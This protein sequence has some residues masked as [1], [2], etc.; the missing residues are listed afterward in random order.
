MKGLKNWRKAKQL[1]L[2]I[3]SAHFLT[4]SSFNPISKIPAEQCPSRAIISVASPAGLPVGYCPSTRRRSSAGSQYHLEWKLWARVSVMQ[5][6]K[7]PWAKQTD[8]P[9]VR[10]GFM[11]T[12][13]PERLIAKWPRPSFQNPSGYCLAYDP[14]RSGWPACFVE[15]NRHR[16]ELPEGRDRADGWKV[17]SR[18][19][20]SP[21]RTFFTI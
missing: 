21:L 3:D 12:L 13:L 9:L 1:R 15:N 19:W 20:R 4:H 8:K 5:L 18:D 10:R 7:V 14:T 16:G 11:N 2:A 6:A 17:W